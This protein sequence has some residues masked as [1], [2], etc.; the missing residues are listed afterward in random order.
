[1]TR[2]VAI[3]LLPFIFQR[4]CMSKLLGSSYN[5]NMDI[6]HVEVYLNQWLKK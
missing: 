2:L 6:N 3:N 1:M 5:K 4:I